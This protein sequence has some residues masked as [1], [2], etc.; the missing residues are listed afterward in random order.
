MLAST[1]RRGG[2]AVFTTTLAY[3]LAARDGGTSVAF[4]L[5]GR[6]TGLLRLLQPMTARTT[7][8]NLDRGFGRLKRLLETGTA[9]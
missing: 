3:Q 8:K 2:L 7:Q 4:S 1:S 9:S 5:T 6:P